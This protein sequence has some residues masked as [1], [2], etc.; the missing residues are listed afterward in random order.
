LRIL[1]ILFGVIIALLI[2]RFFYLKNPKLQNKIIQ[3]S[4][5]SGLA[6][7]FLL[8]ALTGR[9]SWIVAGIVALASLFYRALPLL[10]YVPLLRNLYNFLQ[11][12]RSQSTTSSGGQSS[13]VQSRFLR[14]TLQH[15][16][17]IMEGEILEGQ[18]KGNQLQQLTLQQLMSLLQ[19]CQHD[20]DSWSLLTAYLDRTH[21]N[22]HDQATDDSA[23]HNSQQGSGGFKDSMTRLEAYQILGLEP[24]ATE[25]QIIQ[26]HRHL[27]QKLH[28]DQG[29][30]TY[31]AA[32]INLAKQVLLK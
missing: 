17:G 13:T 26:A 4:I 18:F 24:G 11:S 15:D 9:L 7:I 30:S 23:T 14:M 22:W 8:L 1:L 32:K 12:R 29:G 19:E 10:R 25:Q 31:L 16:T 6:I 28:P 2:I 3:Y 20:K 21:P 27:M 5:F